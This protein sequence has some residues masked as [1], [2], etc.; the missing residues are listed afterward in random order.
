MNKY[1]KQDIIDM[2]IK[3]AKFNTQSSEASNC[4]P[5]TDSQKLFAKVLEN[6]FY[7][8]GI[9]DIKLD[10]NNYL[11]VVLPSNTSKKHSSIAFIAHMDTA[12]A[13]NSKNISPKV[14]E[15]YNG[16]DIV[17]SKSQNIVL[18]QKE[19][20][21]LVNYVGHTLITTDGKTLLGVDDKAG[22]VEIMMTL[23]YFIEHPEVEHGDIEVVITPD[24]EIGEGAN[25]FD[26][27]QLSSDVAFTVDGGMLGEFSYEN[28]NA[29]KVEI[30]IHGKAVHTGAAKGVMIN[31]IDVANNIISRL[32]DQKPSN[33]E[34]YEGFYHI[35]SVVG[36]TSETELK[37]ML[38]DFDIAKLEERKKC[39]Q[40]I[41]YEE[42]Q[43]NDCKID[44]KVSDQYFNM[45]DLIS[46]EIIKIT[47]K[48][49]QLSKVEV[50]EK[51]M[52]GGTDGATI[53]NK[54]IPCPNI[55]TGGE[56]FHGPYEF[57]SVD[58]MHKVIEILINLVKLFSLK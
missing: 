39:I 34:L 2:F 6:D 45:R 30:I 42:Q 14:V 4:H 19:F 17:L 32:P 58:N 55:C 47:R 56:N 37:I 36:D 54:G 53:S 31:S 11:K 23:R 43:Q 21:N 26:W 49:F 44:L 33:T 10:D 41:V 18:S 25:Y 20:P 27:A 1:A 51:A 46:D 50:I 9:K 52:R 22:I 29:A 40:R 24:E 28:F 16:K 13:Y 12:P 3:Y 35:Y 8:L 7:Q 5:S 38:R 48:A 57:V 15:N